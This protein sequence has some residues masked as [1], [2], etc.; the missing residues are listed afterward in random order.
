[1]SVAVILPG[2]MFPDMC[3]YLSGQIVEAE[4]KSPVEVSLSS[5]RVEVYVGLLFVVFQSLYPPAPKTQQN[6]TE[7]H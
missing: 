4:H 5:Q 6:P 1:M 7:T 3:V 2:Q